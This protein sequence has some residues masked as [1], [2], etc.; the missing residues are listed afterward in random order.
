MVGKEIVAE[1]APHT[2]SSMTDGP[3][4]ADDR[5]KKGVFPAWQTQRQ[6]TGPAEILLEVGKLERTEKVI[7]ENLHAVSS[8]LSVAPVAIGMA[9]DRQLIWVNRTFATMFGYEDEQDCLGKTTR[10]IYSS[11]EEFERI[12][13]ILYEK[14]QDNEPAQTDGTF[15]RKDGSTFEGQITIAPT[16][17]LNPRRDVVAAIVD[18][19]HRRQAEEALEKSEQRFQQVVE[20]AREWIWEVDADGLFTYASPVSEGLLGYEPREIVGQKHFYDLFHPDDRE[21]AKQVAL[22]LFPQKMPFRDFISHQMHKNGESVWS[23]TSGVPLLDEKGVLLGYRG[24]NTDITGLKKAEEGLE[25]RSRELGDRVK[26]LNCLYGIS[27]LIE[28]SGLSVDERLQEVVNL[29]P[30]SWRYS[31]IT[32]ARMV[33]EDQEYRSERF[34]EP[35]SKQSA[36]IKAHGKRIGSLEV[37]YLAERPECHE[38]PFLKEERSL[39]DAVAERLGRFIERKRAEEIVREQKD[40]LNTVLDSLTHPF[41]VID[42]AD[43][44]V[45]MANS[46]AHV[47]DIPSN[48]KCHVLT[49]HT[50]KPC[51]G[52]DHL[53]PLDET[54][55]TRRPVVV[56]HVHRDGD[57]NLRNVE[58]HAYPIF[59]NQGD[60]EQVI[61]YALD[62]TERKQAEEELAASLAF[63]KQLLATAATAIFTVDSDRIV[64]SVNDELCHLTGFERGEIIG[65]PCAIFC[66]EPCTLR[67]GLFDPS[68]RGRIFRRRCKIKTKD[69][70]LLTALKNADLVRDAEGHV[71][72]GMES[73]VDVT[74]LMQATERAATEAGKLRSMIEGMEEGIVVAEADGTITEVNSWFLEK[75]GMKRND[76]AG[77]SMWE[78]HPESKQTARIRA[79]LEDYE[80]GRR[81]E[82]L[83]VNRE[84]LGMHLCFRVQ[85]IFE[86]ET[87]RGVILNVIDIT[88]Q[89]KARIV[90]E[91]ASR[92]KS[93]FLANMSHEIRT[94]MN[95]VLGMTELALLTNLTA[96]Q[97]EYLEAVK[98]SADSLLSLINDILDFSKMEAGKFALIRTD[99][100]LRDCVGNTMNTLA[101]HAHSKGLE[102]AQRILPDVPDAM[103]GDPGRLRQILV[104]LVGNALKFTEKGEVTVL[105]EVESEADAEARLHFSVVD[106][107]PGI[108]ADMQD[109]IFKAFEQVDGSMTRE[110]GGTGLGLAISSQLVKLMNGRIQLESEE[111]KGSTF[112]F[113][114]CLGVGNE[115]AQASSTDKNPDLKDLP[116]LVVDDNATNRQILEEILLNW[117]MRPTAVHSGPAALDAIRSATRDNR[118]FAMALID[119]M[120]PGMDGFEL[121]ERINQD[122]DVTLE[123]IIMLTS[124]GQR[125]DDARCQDLGIAAYLRKPIMQSHL[126]DAII[127]TMHKQ[128]GVEDKAPPI[129]RHTLREAENRLNI[130]LAEDNPVNQKLAMKMLEKMGHTVSVARNGREALAALEADSFDLVFMDVQMPE[131]DGFEATGL[132]RDSE[133]RT[134]SHVPIVAMTAHAM[135]GDKERCLEAGMDAYVSKPIDPGKLYDVIDTI[136]VATDEHD[137]AIPDA[138]SSQYVLD[139]SE[140]LNRVGGDRELLMDLVS[141]FLEDYPTT[142]REIREATQNRDPEGLRR[143]AHA[144]KGA[145]ANFAAR[146]AV[147]TAEKLEDLGKQQDMTQ[148]AEILPRL[149]KEIDGVRRALESIQMEALQ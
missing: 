68:R 64:T 55:K 42:V 70:R 127:M 6:S 48:L 140:L 80:S 103:F 78:F 26:E 120:M 138:G 144:L 24:S 23:S 25:Q 58:V 108:P 109:K 38:G 46:A 85:P 44:T 8:I 15:V 112:H 32:W 53:C 31:E 96:E 16:D 30:S 123:K 81:R 105:V 131:M 111:G 62:I 101:V 98:M 35:V 86:D 137:E 97:R 14:L 33:V 130:L 124:G 93:E 75:T 37:G 77:K 18:L 142:L 146:A 10:I 22:Q 95:G 72:G 88:D 5:L 45:K 65:K 125:G 104:N 100:S 148:A 149:E 128:S 119:F 52:E 143:S 141:L 106:T 73:F 57:G 11:Q 107:G 61:E 13:E 136:T 139:E 66:D 84:M 115:A 36:Q 4:F 49:H 122:P 54:R 63:Q 92:A 2:K 67:C 76:I 34:G 126:F 74:E 17:P 87:Y 114:V 7:S 51:G 69:G 59:G 12:G 60:L 102:L 91:E 83:E 71:I 39:I 47:G 19:S 113:T 116:V 56:E 117:G 27:K 82:S 118:P 43:Y 89:A 147:E 129:T 94:P 110:H 28:N 9:K 79:L 3:D 134:G 90:A 20:N 29:I 1:R 50:T 41:Y 132:I 145:V 21:M 99:F 121:V 40:F 133:E 135:K